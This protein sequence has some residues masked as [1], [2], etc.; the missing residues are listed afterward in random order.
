MNHLQQTW[1]KRITA[2]NEPDTIR[3]YPL[4]KGGQFA[5]SK[6][7]LDPDIFNN[8]NIMH[9]WIR[10]AIIAI[11]D[12][13]WGPIYGDDWQTWT[14][15]Y[16]AGSLASY[17]WG[18]PDFDTLIGV[19][20]PVFVKSHSEFKGMSE[21]EIC[22]HL[23]QGFYTGIDPLITD[24]TFPPAQDTQHIVSFLG[25][26][27]IDAIY[28]TV[29]LGTTPF[30][31]MEV[32]FFVNKDSWDIRNIHPY[33]AYEMIENKWWVYPSIMGK[34]W[35]AQKLPHSFWEKMADL[36]DEIKEALSTDD[37]TERQ[38]DAQAIYDR[39]HG[40]RSKG[41]SQGYGIGD[42]KS[43]QWVVLARWGL[44]GALE[45]A[46]HPGKPSAHPAPAT[47]SLH[48]V[49]DLHDLWG[50]GERGMDSIFPD[51]IAKVNSPFRTA[52]RRKDVEDVEWDKVRDAIQNPEKHMDDIDPRDLKGT[53]PSVTRQA[54]DHY[55]KNDYRK[56]PGTF[57]DQGNPGNTHPFVYSR[58]GPG[59]RVDHILL[60]GHHRALADL[61]KGRK[62]R[63]IH[64]HGGWGPAR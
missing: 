41:F 47:A 42:L 16:L 13:W 48:K 3:G 43:L 45:E 52:G 60:S 54:A 17:W 33:A 12:A 31:P 32:T 36:A 55:M 39:I 50:S 61:L 34:T 8:Q 44:L 29:P 22:T 27:P 21:A 18:T 53:Q 40:D 63:A 9:P 14:R 26:R 38:E 6:K 30:G 4:P 23:T 28:A 11:L 25:G 19:N 35:G 59:D 1:A 24:F 51:G 56:N 10:G 15:I 57:A 62:T 46:V 2:W 7:F 5:P 49:S 37:P 64:I 20:I 58:H